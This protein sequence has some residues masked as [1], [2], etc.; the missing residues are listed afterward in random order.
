MTP[1]GERREENYFCDEPGSKHYRRMQRGRA[2]RKERGRLRELTKDAN[3]HHR[4]LYYDEE[5]S[6]H[7]DIIF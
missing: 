5:P 3:S 4:A 1:Y 6:E 7:P 2:R